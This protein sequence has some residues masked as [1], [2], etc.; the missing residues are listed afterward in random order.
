MPSYENAQRKLSDLER[1]CT[2]AVNELQGILAIF[3]EFQIKKLSGVD[4]NFR[5]S[6]YGIGNVKPIDLAI[7]Q[8]KTKVKNTYR[9]YSRI[10]PEEFKFLNSEKIYNFECWPAV[11]ILGSVELKTSVLKTLKALNTRLKGIQDKKKELHDLAFNKETETRALSSFYSLGNRKL[12]DSFSTEKSIIKDFEREQLKEDVSISKETNEGVRSSLEGG[13][14]S[15]TKKLWDTLGLESVPALNIVKKVEDFQFYLNSLQY[16][17]SMRYCRDRSSKRDSQSLQNS[18][19]SNSQLASEQSTEAKRQSDKNKKG[20]GRQF[21][22]SPEFK[23]IDRRAK[24]KLPMLLALGTEEHT[25][26][27]NKYDNLVRSI[28]ACNTRAGVQEYVYEI[29]RLMLS[30][31]QVRPRNPRREQGT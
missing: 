25:Q 29:K 30:I 6:E 21:V 22:K 8:I 3:T 19:E 12:L 23:A 27:K 16:P 18:R 13:G 5:K 28:E 2:K 1:D 31:S 24:L 14:D 26:A 11:N 7:T 17:K 15:F 10:F 9:R 20:Y 4:L